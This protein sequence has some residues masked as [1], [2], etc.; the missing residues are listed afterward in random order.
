MEMM[1]HIVAHSLTVCEVALTLA[2]GLAEEN[3]RLNRD[4]VQ[5]GALLH[6]ITKTRSFTTGENHAESGGAL[7]AELGFQDVGNIVRQHVR[8][9]AYP[10]E[11]Q[12]SEAEIVNYA[13]KRVLHDEVVPLDRR[14]RYIVDRYCHG[15]AD[16]RRVGRLWE[17]TRALEA[18]LFE[19][20]PFGI[21]EL[22]SRVAAED[23]RRE[24]EGYR[25][26]CPGSNS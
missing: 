22:N 4:L 23:H 5:A 25:A 1:D 21:D 19:H 13:D 18:R 2:D 6:D 11:A 10:R 3:V 14:M 15:E 12:F 20:L 16:R 24:L 17:K 7:L 8:L 26:T 9:D